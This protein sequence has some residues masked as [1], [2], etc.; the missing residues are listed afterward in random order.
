MTTYGRAD[1]AALIHSRQQLASGVG[2][3][4]RR[5][6]VLPFAP[7]DVQIPARVGIYDPGAPEAVVAEPPACLGSNFWT[8][9]SGTWLARAWHADTDTLVS[10]DGAM[11]MDRTAHKRVT[12]Q[13][14]KPALSTD[15]IH[16]CFASPTV[17]AV[18]EPAAGI[19]DWHFVET[20]YANR[21]WH[22]KQTIN[23]FPFYLVGCAQR[24]KSIEFNQH[25]TLFNF[26]W[27]FK[28]P[29]DPAHIGDTP[30][31][32][33]RTGHETILTDRQF[34]STG[35]RRRLSK[36]KLVT[37]E[38]KGEVELRSS[39]YGFLPGTTL[40]SCALLEAEG[41]ADESN[42][43]NL[44]DL[45]RLLSFGQPYHGLC[46]PSAIT[47]ADGAAAATPTSYS[48]PAYANTRYFKHSSPP[49]EPAAPL[50]PPNY[51]S[52]GYQFLDDIVL[53]AGREYGPG[54][55]GVPNE[56]CWPH[57]GSDGI[58]RVLG[59]TLVSDTATTTTWNVIKF[60]TLFPVDS[61]FAT[62]TVIGSIAIDTTDAALTA[63]VPSTTT[64]RTYTGMYDYQLPAGI[65]NTPAAMPKNDYYAAVRLQNRFM[66]EFSPDGRKIVLMRGVYNAE[67][68][69]V[70][71]GGINYGLIATVARID[72]SGDFVV[73][74]PEYLFQFSYDYDPATF[75]QQFC[76]GFAYNKT[77]ALKLWTVSETWS[78]TGPP[79]DVVTP[80]W[81]LDACS[82]NGTDGTMATG[83]H[84]F[85]GSDPPAKYFRPYGYYVRV[86]NNVIF[87]VIALTS[88]NTIEFSTP[89]GSY[90]YSSV[91]PTGYATAR[92]ASWNPRTEQLRCAAGATAGP[93]SWI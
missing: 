87:Q 13:G 20:A 82:Y 25:D 64:V 14:G 51:A 92:F 9:T 77:G 6:R 19:N 17:G 90:E 38:G 56:R 80:T 23:V 43:G 15:P 5:N 35:G 61:I 29:T 69:T 73:G 52:A 78:K 48:G 45:S 22:A 49:G 41:W 57:L 8:Y 24:L 66:V 10:S 32:L 39:P 34:S 79:T 18:P 71:N 44:T 42:R 21:E 62:S 3:S 28:T 26:R 2:L 88:G 81:V 86:S 74:T 37:P 33:N 31:C 89:S 55:G 12:F 54:Y 27:N 85:S 70:A 53:R 50:L 68:D 40:S 58:V 76:V 36:F 16:L 59:L 83:F 65:V 11:R 47:T 63:L 75:T 93:I 72:I 4:T 91:M 30:T 7:L 1:L 84:G 67:Q 46:T 60:N